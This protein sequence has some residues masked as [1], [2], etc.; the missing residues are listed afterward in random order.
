MRAL[1]TI[2]FAVV[3]LGCVGPFSEDFEAR[4]AT[5]AAA[6]QSDAI[7][8]HRWIPAILPET[9]TDIV[10]FHNIDTNATWGCFRLNGG[11]DQL[12]SLVRAKAA[13]E[14]KGAVSG[15]PRQWF[16][17]R[18]WWPETMTKGTVEVLE[19]TEPAAAPALEPT[20][21]R[22]GVDRVGDT[23]CFRRRR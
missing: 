1:G 10:E 7:G 12:I 19:F 9:A 14:S 5:V 15:G 4:Y 6:R 11:A 13:R 21:V 23:A 18:P 16:R 22:V 20:T 2:A 8:D 3:Q 17:T